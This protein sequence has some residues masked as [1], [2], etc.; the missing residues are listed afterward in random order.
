MIQSYNTAWHFYQGLRR[1]WPMRLDFVFSSR[2]TPCSS[3]IC[4][5]ETANKRTKC[6]EK[7]ISAPDVKRSRLA[8]ERSAIS[9]CHFIVV[10][11][12]RNTGSETAS[13]LPQEQNTLDSSVPM[14]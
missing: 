8:V 11:S 14:K 9:P 3:E 7:S 12:G 10:P 13:S 2:R 6:E 1:H 5:P 4:K